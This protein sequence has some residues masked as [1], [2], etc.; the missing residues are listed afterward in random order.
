MRQ[1]FELLFVIVAV[2]LL[3]VAVTFGAGII[4]A[5][6]VA[7]GAL[8]LAGMGVKALWRR[9]GGLR[10]RLDAQIDADWPRFI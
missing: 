10:R 4:L 9:R 3:A 2:A 8:A 1:T 6:V 5:L 7:F